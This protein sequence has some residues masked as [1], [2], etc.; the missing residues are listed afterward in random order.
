[1]DAARDI[2]HMCGIS[3]TPTF[4]FYKR[5]EKVDELRW[6]NGLEVDEMCGANEAALEELI[7]E[8]AYD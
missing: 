1:V 8:H 2:A 7:A 4:Q 5:G 6:K 3:A